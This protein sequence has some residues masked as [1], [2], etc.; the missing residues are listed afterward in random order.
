MTALT[1]FIL[2]MGLYP[3]VQHKAKV[4]IDAIVGN[5][6]IPDFE[7][8]HKLPYIDALCAEVLRWRPILPLS[9]WGSGRTSRALG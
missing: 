4:E 8:R 3:E 9:M 1:N 2:A 7:D 6:R 5:E